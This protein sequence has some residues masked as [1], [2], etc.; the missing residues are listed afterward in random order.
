MRLSHPLPPFAFLSSSRWTWCLSCGLFQYRLEATTF[1]SKLGS[2]IRLVDGRLVEIIVRLVGVSAR[3][4]AEMGISFLVDMNIRFL[5]MSCGVIV[6]TRIRRLVPQLVDVST[7]FLIEMSV[8]FLIDMSVRLLNM[9]FSSVVLWLVVVN[10]GFLIDMSIRLLDKSFSFVV[11]TSVGFSLLANSRVVEKE[12]K[13]LLQSQQKFGQS[14]QRA[15]AEIKQIMQHVA[16]ELVLAGVIKMFGVV[17]DI[18]P[19]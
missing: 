12:L 8:M 16:R 3:F 17:L 11:E 19:V 2:S 7:K 4:L 13:R 15:C 10:I 14:I 1:S 5:N 9:S 6:E 18:S